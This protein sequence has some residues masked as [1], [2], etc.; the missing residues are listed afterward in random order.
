MISPMSDLAVRSEP[1]GQPSRGLSR[2]GYRHADGKGGNIPQSLARH[3]L[4]RF[5]FYACFD[6]HPQAFVLCQR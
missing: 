2:H 4:N 5:A 6:K 1:G 3:F